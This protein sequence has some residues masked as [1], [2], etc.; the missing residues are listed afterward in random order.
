MLKL[1][2]EVHRKVNVFHRGLLQVWGPLVG[3]GC[4]ALTLTVLGWM[5]LETVWP[6][7]DCKAKLRS[8]EMRSRSPKLL[9]KPEALHPRVASQGPEPNRIQRTKGGQRECEMHK[10]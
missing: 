5:M 6:D 7:P 4:Q 1:L 10:I 3:R 8:S 2:N 9:L